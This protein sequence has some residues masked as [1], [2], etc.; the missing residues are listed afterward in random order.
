MV[1]ARVTVTVSKLLGSDKGQGSF[2]ATVRVR[3][4]LWLRVACSSTLTTY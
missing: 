4:K 1:D 2:G 3:I